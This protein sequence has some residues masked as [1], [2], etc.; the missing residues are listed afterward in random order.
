M[1]GKN[2][3]SLLSLLFDTDIFLYPAKLKLKCMR[4]PSL[5]HIFIYSLSDR[6]L[7]PHCLYL[8]LVTWTAAHLCC[9]KPPPQY[10]SPSVQQH[11]SGLVAQP[12]RC[13]ILIPLGVRGRWRQM[14]VFGWLLVT[15][16]RQT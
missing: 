2:Q 8:L 7:T 10:H 13:H 11:L 3:C 12:A 15:R 9:V 6:C 4:S 5:P 14:L 1:G 16:D